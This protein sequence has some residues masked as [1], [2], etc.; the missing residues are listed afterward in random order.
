MNILSLLMMSGILTCGS[1]RAVKNL[2]KKVIEADIQAW[3]ARL[4]RK[5]W[6]AVCRGSEKLDR[7]DW[8]AQL[9]FRSRGGGK[10]EEITAN[11]VF[12]YAVER[13]LCG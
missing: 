10:S 9:S 4:F 5:S 12:K 8:L 13:G 2:V 3:E 6:M 7:K 11:V 1:W